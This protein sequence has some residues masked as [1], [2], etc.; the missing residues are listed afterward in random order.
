MERT[1]VINYENG[2][3][4]K[5]WDSHCDTNLTKLGGRSPQ[6]TYTDRATSACRRS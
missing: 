4:M 3:L 5:T 6:A 1:T 2:N